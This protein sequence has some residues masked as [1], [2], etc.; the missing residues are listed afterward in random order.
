MDQINHQIL[1]LK[2]RNTEALHSGN[3]REHVFNLNGGTIGSHQ[4]VEWQIQDFYNSVSGMHA[5]INSKD[6]YYFI[7]PIEDKLFINHSEISSQADSV[8]LQH[9][10]EIRIGSLII[11]ARIGADLHQLLDD[12]LDKS[13]SQIISINEISLNDMLNAE[14]K[15]TISHLYDHNI[16]TEQKSEIVDP[17]EAIEKDSNDALSEFYKNISG[18]ENNASE[19]P[20]SLVDYNV[21]QG[22]LM[23]DN[24]IEVPN[25][26]ST[27]YDDNAYAMENVNLSL[28]PF[29]RGLGVNL[30][31]HNTEE[32]NALLEELG[33]TLKATVEGLLKLNLSKD[34]LKNKNLRPIE[35]NPLRLN[36][37][38]SDTMALLFSEQ[39]CTVY[40]SAPA[41]VKESLENVAIHNKAS[42]MATKYAL[43]A[44]LD[45]FS[46]DQLS[47]RF[48][49]YRNSRKVKNHDGTWSWNMYCSYYKELS[50]NRQ[51]GFEKLFWEHYEQEY[52]KQLR[53]LNQERI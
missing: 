4:N 52:D 40:L 30:N 17:F 38:Y 33:E 15:N 53:R 39:P 28:V 48:E 41:A 47:N 5:R 25:C 11:H 13:P 32:A 22:S 46:P 50:S 20:K 2:I 19:Q 24:F 27:L 18:H 51:Q 37:N 7:Q 44:M 36:Q 8:K 21:K 9:G 42:Q 31:I 12:P 16:D 3:T 10:D 29:L 23:D 49:V 45:A 43:S 34:V 26:D 35:D 1:Q 14:D 6:G